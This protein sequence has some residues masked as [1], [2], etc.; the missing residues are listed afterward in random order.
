MQRDSRDQARRNEILRLVHERGAISRAE[1]G[2]Q[3]GYS[4]FLISKLTESLLRQGFLRETGAG[5]S[6]G[7]RPPALLT[8]NPSLG[9]LVGLHLGT[10][11]CR[12]AITDINGD[13]LHYRKVPSRAQDG[14]EVALPYLVQEIGA[15]LS[16]ARVQRRAL[17]G[18]GIGISGVL[19][20]RA[21]MTLIWPKAPLW[22][23]VPVQRFFEQEYGVDVAID[24]TPRTLATA[25]RRWGRAKGLDSFVYVAAGAG[26]GAALCLDGRW[27]GG[28]GGFAGEF[29]HMTL[30]EDGPLCACGNRG[31]LE[32]LVSANTLIQRARFAVRHGA[33]LPL[34][35]L[36]G[37][38]ASRL[39]V[40][41][42]AQAA[43][44]GD[45]FCAGELD[46]AG[47]SLGLGMAALIQLLNPAAVILG[48]GLAR[49]AGPALVRA[50]EQVIAR[51]C[52]PQPA[53]Q[54]KVLLAESTEQD[55]AR[56]AAFQVA[57]RALEKTL[58]R[59]ASARRDAQPAA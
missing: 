58:V 25:E 6:T 20:R 33:A 24:D 35:K 47:Q 42:I 53:S 36:C 45:L 31:C 13:L 30:R 16:A 9:R 44:A 29:G 51:R 10:I 46:R 14:P 21:G 43:A 5:A 39:S 34:W 57:G 26:V 38:D 59:T 28:A 48:G 37:G 11:N 52:L 32:A 1:L 15:C 40:E 12:I 4:P 50:A 27:Y 23:N 8:V 7:G 17:K 2:L 56:A 22:T 19:D 54:A 3:T 55:W 18:V 49:A 41:M